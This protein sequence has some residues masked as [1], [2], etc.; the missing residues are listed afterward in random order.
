MNTGLTLFRSN[1]RTIQLANRASLAIKNGRSKFEQTALNE[2]LLE[3]NCTWSEPERLPFGGSAWQNWH[4]L[5]ATPLLGAC[6]QGLKVVI[7]PFYS[8]TRYLDAARVITNHA[9]A[10]HPSLRNATVVQEIASICETRNESR[11]KSQ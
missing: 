6:A 9:I 2:E 1:P 3:L 4:S 10:M 5:V 11:S 7:L 8:A